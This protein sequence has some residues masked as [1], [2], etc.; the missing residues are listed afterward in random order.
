MC[1]Q[2]GNWLI[3]GFAT[4]GAFPMAFYQWWGRADSAQQGAMIWAIVGAFAVAVIIG[5]SC[6]VAG[7][8]AAPLLA[9]VLGTILGAIAAALIYAQ[10]LTWSN[11]EVD[12]EGLGYATFL[13]GIAGGAGGSL[14]AWGAKAAGL[15]PKPV[16]VR[17]VDG[18]VQG[19]WSRT[20]GTKSETLNFVKESEL[21]PD[22][23]RPL[24]LRFFQKGTKK[25]A[26]YRVSKLP[27]G[28]FKFERLTYARSTPTGGYGKKYVMGVNDNGAVFADYKF[29]P[30]PDGSINWN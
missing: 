14:G 29:G 8:I 20:F 13:G 6:V 5:V 25:T 21:I 1:A 24:G 22:P 12:R 7:C 16:R 9:P 26:F 28:G 19:S 18:P 15:G 10:I 11:H 2:T 4:A 17:I 3:D 30:Y 27:E 23:V